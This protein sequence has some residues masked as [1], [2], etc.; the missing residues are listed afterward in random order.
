[1]LKAAGEQ[2]GKRTVREKKTTRPWLTDGVCKLVQAKKQA[3]GTEHSED[4]AVQARIALFREEWAE[5][6]PQMEG[7]FR[8]EIRG[9]A[10]AEGSTS[11]LL[12]LFETAICRR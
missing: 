8:N 6:Y 12:N 11:I 5:A 7:L 9:G 10:A 3:E 1:M 4:D 2:V